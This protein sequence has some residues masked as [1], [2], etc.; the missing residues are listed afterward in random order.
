M[1]GNYI[2]TYIIDVAALVFLCCLIR[3]NNILNKNRKGPFYLSITLTVLIVLS[4][5]GTLIAGNGDADLRIL[6]IFCNVF[7]F[8]LTPMLPIILIAIFDVGILRTNKL[9]MLPSIL[10]MFA[11]ILSPWLGLI[12]Y[13]D[14]NNYYERGNVFYFFVVAYI[15]NLTILLI[16]AVRTGQKYYSPIKVKIIVLSLFA[17][18]GTSIQLILPFVYSSWHSVT[19]SLILYYLLLSEF[20][21]SF[22]TLTRLYNRAAYEKMAN[23]LEGRKQYSIVVMD[24]NNF[25]EI[26]DTYGHDFGDAVLKKV[27]TVITKSFDT[28]C[29]CYRV[30]GD[31]FYIVDS[32]TDLVILERQLK[33]MTNN[34]EKER[35]NDSR[36][37]TVAFG[38][39]IYK[40]EKGIGYKEVFKEADNQM[41]YFKRI[42]KNMQKTI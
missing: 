10:N 3:S 7:G 14:A 39:S 18:A 32:A 6:N 11:T 27:A 42:Q 31:E 13:V 36:L 15:I 23:K 8:A 19:L 22:D 24:I 1:L 9:I 37:P 17:V 33:S 34:L 2:A 16:S 25:K 4:E 38:Y 35:Q 21:G 20:D 41:Y 40:G 12:F 28:R 26:N 5:A 29:T 30:G